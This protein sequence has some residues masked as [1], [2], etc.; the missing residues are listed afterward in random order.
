MHH[1]HARGDTLHLGSPAS[2][3]S[4]TV[5]LVERASRVLLA[6]DTSTCTSSSEPGCVKPTQVPMIAIALAIV[7]DV[8]RCLPCLC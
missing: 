2:G 3:A 8:Y 1:E 5:R 6:R 4:R 7:Y